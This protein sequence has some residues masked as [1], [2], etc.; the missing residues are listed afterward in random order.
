MRDALKKSLGQHILKNPGVVSVLVEKGRVRPSDTVLEIGPGSGNLTLKLLG[1]AKKVIAVEK[2][3][4]IAS[5]LLKRV[6][7][8]R[9]K[10]QLIIGDALEIDYPS[11]DLCISNTPYQISSPLVFKLLDYKFRACVLMFQREFALR[12]CASVGDTYYCRLSVSVQIRANVQ[13]VMN[14]SKKSFR[15]PPKVESSI[16]K[17]EPKRHPPGINLQEFDG[18]VKICFSRKHKTIGAIF[19]QTAIRNLVFNNTDNINNI[20][21]TDNTNIPATET[22]MDIENSIYLNENINSDE[23]I[24]SNNSNNDLFLTDAD[25]SRLTKALEESNMAGERAARMTVE[26]FIF[27]LIKFKENGIS[28]M[29]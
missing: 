12:L 4:K 8:K 24:N 22:P 17:I 13:H 3:K 27:L 11:F 28:F 10:M 6:G 18:L 5:D 21:N 20:N 7:N 1:S 9:L 2:D 16:V 14:V 23:D 26:D 25:N 29:S 15:P 19:K